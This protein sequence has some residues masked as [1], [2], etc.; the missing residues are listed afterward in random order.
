MVPAN[1][2]GTSHEPGDFAR[3]RAGVAVPDQRMLSG[4]SADDQRT[5]DEGHSPKV[6]WYAAASMRPSMAPASAGTS[7]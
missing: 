4:R 2:S 3:V 6:D 1:L 5:I 7:S